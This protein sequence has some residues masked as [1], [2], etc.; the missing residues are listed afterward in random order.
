MVVI[1][2]TAEKTIHAAVVAARGTPVP[3]RRSFF[4][5]LVRVAG[6]AFADFS[7]KLAGAPRGK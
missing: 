7:G 1:S 2:E 4:D 6:E 5:Q 3:M